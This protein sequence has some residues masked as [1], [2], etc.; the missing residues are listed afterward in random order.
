MNKLVLK[1]P[2]QLERKMERFGWVDWPEVALRSFSERLE[3]IEELESERKTAEISGI[4]PD[5]KREVRESLVEEVINSC[6]DTKSGKGMTI[7]EFNKWCD[8]L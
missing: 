2:K 5:D 8:E 6:E 3:D 4:S 1:I 7:E